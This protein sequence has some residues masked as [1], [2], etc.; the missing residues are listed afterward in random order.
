MKAD[1]FC[2][3][4]PKP[5]PRKPKARKRLPAVSPK[6]KAERPLLDA[7]RQACF[8]RDGHR[9]RRCGSAHNLHAHHVRRRSQGGAHDPRNLLTLCEKCHRHVHLHV[10]ESKEAGWLD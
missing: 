3:P 2:T 10:A 5:E 7:A 1:E 6:K 4:R 9:C 8:D